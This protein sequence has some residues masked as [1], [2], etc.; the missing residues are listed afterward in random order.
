MFVV[1]WHYHWPDAYRK[2][3]EKGWV[4]HISLPDNYLSLDTTRLAWYFKTGRSEI[5]WYYKETRL[6]P[7]QR[8]QCIKGATETF[9]KSR[10]ELLRRNPR[11]VRQAL[12]R[13]G[14]SIDDLMQN[15][16]LTGGSP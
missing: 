7:E 12:K 4:L 10:Q 8:K 2:V 9:T 6:Q 13:F 15:G 14:L 5:R 1:V 16:V 11:A 3:S